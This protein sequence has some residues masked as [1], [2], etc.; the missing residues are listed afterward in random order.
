[1]KNNI[2]LATVSGTKIVTGKRFDDI[3]RATLRR[4]G[5][6]LNNDSL[7]WVSEIVYKYLLSVNI[8]YTEAL[9]D[10]QRLEPLA[11]QRLW[12]ASRLGIGKTLVAGDVANLFT[13]LDAIA[14]F[15]WGINDMWLNEEIFTLP[16][17]GAVVQLR[18]TKQPTYDDYVELFTP[19]LKENKMTGR[20]TNGQEYDVAPDGRWT[21]TDA[22]ASRGIGN[23]TDDGDNDDTFTFTLKVPPEYIEP[24]KRRRYIVVPNNLGNTLSDY[25][26]VVY[27]DVERMVFEEAARNIKTQAPNNTAYQYQQDLD[28]M[29]SKAKKLEVELQVTK[30]AADKQKAVLREEITKI[31]EKAETAIAEANDAVTQLSSGAA[32]IGIV[33]QITHPSYDEESLEE[34]QLVRLHKGIAAGSI[35]RIVQ[36]VDNHQVMV[37]VVD[38]YENVTG[39]RMLYNYRPY[40][41]V[42]L[43]ENEESIAP[44]YNHQYV[45]GSEVYAEVKPEGVAYKTQ[46]RATVMS[47]PTVAGDMVIQVQD[48]EEYT[49]NV[50]Y[51]GFITVAEDLN[52]WGYV[53]VRGELRPVAFPKRSDI[54]VGQTVLLNDAGQIIE[55]ADVL[56]QF[57]DIYTFKKV[58]AG[59]VS[60]FLNKDG[61]TVI[62]YNVC[63][64][65]L[66]DGDTVL[67][68]ASNTVAYTKYVV[69]QESNVFSQD[70][71]VSWDDIGGCEDAKQAFMEAIEYPITHAEMYAAY[72]MK[73]PKGIM[74]YGSPG[75]GKTMIA[76]AA[77]TSLKK[78]HGSDADT[79]FIYLKGPEVLSQWVGVAEEKIRN[80]FKQA[81]AHKEKHGF[82]AIVFI[83]EADAILRQRGS[84]KSSDVDKTIVPQFLAEM[85]GLEDHACILV[86]ATNRPD[87]LDS[88]VTRNGR[89]DRK[90]KVNRPDAAVATQILNLYLRDVPLKKGL[91]NQQV[92]EYTVTKLFD[93]TLAIKA[94]KFKTGMELLTLGQVVNGA[95]LKGIVDLAKS[96]ALCRDL[97][98]KKATGVTLED[99]KQALRTTWE[100]NLNVNYDED[101]Q[102]IVGT[103]YKDVVGIEKIEGIPNAIA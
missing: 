56:P 41:D 89:V 11:I 95:M 80:I 66:Q 16:Q 42:L 13:Q 53:V 63:Q 22:P 81:R 15:G 75:T 8:P 2:I 90:V 62:C 94:I 10:V 20:D 100:E 91:T 97:A 47:T 71:G 26:E 49:V 52:G 9:V 45:V 24:P 19:F 102:D 50:G 36:I 5:G 92:A 33:I 101:L 84:S 39:V 7:G 14:P 38:R 74:L 48:G 30:D 65:P 51:S 37:E 78:F 103:R 86:L 35:G 64:E 79:A 12:I 82:P 18:E 93:P 83:D 69:E 21:V 58:V 27:D 87:S 77:V 3:V 17:L 32:A 25:A 55:Q 4:I 6:A 59:K 44:A 23:D 31:R 29:S 43:I 1:M 70:T 67:M 98:A 54:E 99:F 46:V 88:A 57:G 85:D 76:K 72:G 28:A 40:S 61:A 34:G 96:S 68:D 60:E 73:P